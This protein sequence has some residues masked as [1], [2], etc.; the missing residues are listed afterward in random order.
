[1]SILKIVMQFVDAMT[2]LL[3]ANSEYFNSNSDRMYIYDT[4]KTAF[5]EC[6]IRINDMETKLKTKL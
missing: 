1:M 6:R 5:M 3:N 4:L 2:H